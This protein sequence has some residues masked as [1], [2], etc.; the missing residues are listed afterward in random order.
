MGCT[1]TGAARVNPSFWAKEGMPPWLCW[2]CSS[3]R[4]DIKGSR[5][6]Q[7]GLTADKKGGELLTPDVGPPAL[8]EA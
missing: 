6:A 4:D 8:Q 2:V 5:A 7:L 3:W 1:S